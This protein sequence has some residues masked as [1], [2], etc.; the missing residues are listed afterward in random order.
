MP[1][2]QYTYHYI[3]ET[4]CLVTGRYYIGMHSTSNLEDGYIGSGK[5]LRF[6]INKHG[7]ENHIKKILEFLPDRIA[8]K[9]REKELVNIEV[10]TDTVCMNLMVGGEGGKISDEQQLRRAKAAGK[11]SAIARKNNPELK[12]RLRIISSKSITESHKSGKIK[13][14]TFTGKNHSIDSKLKIGKSNSVSQ[15]G[16]RNS[17]YDKIWIYSNDHKIS[18]SITKEKLS[19]YL[20]EGWI[21][22]RKLKF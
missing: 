22:G 16:N 21:K 20:E 10:L 7:H 9:Q 19:V 4:T 17:N 12:E 13:Y 6:S 11:A 8:L 14:D 18:K 1:R 3:Y 2:K 5:R 15:K